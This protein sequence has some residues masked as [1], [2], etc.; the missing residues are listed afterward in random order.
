MESKINNAWDDV[1]NDPETI[2][3]F[4]NNLQDDDIISITKKDLEN[5][6]SYAED[7]CYVPW[8]D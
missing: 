3:D 7:A 1:K 6:I 2:Q 8:N 5:I 4:F